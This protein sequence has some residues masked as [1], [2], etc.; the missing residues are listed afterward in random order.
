MQRAIYRDALLCFCQIYRGKIKVS[1]S[2]H[3]KLHKSKLNGPIMKFN[4]NWFWEF[5]NDEIAH[6]KYAAE[7]ENSKVK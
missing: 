2:S 7:H 5:Q 3:T 6:A 4:K 1:K